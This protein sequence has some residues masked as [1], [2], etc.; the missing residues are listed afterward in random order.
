[1][2]SLRPR[3]RTAVG[4]LRRLSTPASLVGGYTPPTVQPPPDESV[5]TYFYLGVA[6][7]RCLASPAGITLAVC[8]VVHQSIGYTRGSA[9]KEESAFNVF[10]IRSGVVA[11]GLLVVLPLTRTAAIGGVVLKF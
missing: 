7:S 6:S 9:N 5:A 11:G 1:M 3:P 4:Q 2:L 8:R 10:K